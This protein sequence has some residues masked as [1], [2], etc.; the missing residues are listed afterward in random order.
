MTTASPQDSD[1]G[2]EG[3]QLE[4][5][6]S[7]TKPT[8]LAQMKEQIKIVMAREVWNIASYTRSQT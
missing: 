6:V 1:R 4:H 8:F 3:Q 2:V 5:V 7:D